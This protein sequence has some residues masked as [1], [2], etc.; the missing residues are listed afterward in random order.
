MSSGCSLII[1]AFSLRA[2]GGFEHRVLSLLAEYGLVVSRT[3]QARGG[4]LL[5]AESSNCDSF[6]LLKLRQDLQ[7]R[8]QQLGVDFRIQ[9]EELFRAMHILATPGDFGAP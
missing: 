1:A 2:E 6:N 5:F 3:E 9:R 8:G 7:N 4:L